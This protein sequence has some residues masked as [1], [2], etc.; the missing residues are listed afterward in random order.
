MAIQLVRTTTYFHPDLLMRLKKMAID[1]NKRFYELLNEKLEQSI[2]TTVSTKKTATKPFSFT[3]RYSPFSMK[4][5]VKKITRPV[6][7][8]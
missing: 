7:Y 1:E 6:A 5:K 2:T 4:M 8:E 3:D